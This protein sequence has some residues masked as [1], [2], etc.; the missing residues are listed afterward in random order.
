MPLKVVLAIDR[1]DDLGRKANI[2]S[3]VIGREENLN[4]AIALAAADPEDSDINTI[5]GALKIYDDL[6]R[7][8]EDVEIVTICGNES[9][10]LFSD[11]EIANQL[12]EIKRK[13]GAESVVVVTDGSED[14][15][16]MPIIS[17]RFKID[18]VRRI[19]V[20]Q[21]KTIESTYFM[22]KRMLNDPKI[23]RITLAPLG[24]I[25]LVYSIFLILRISEMGSG[26]IIFFIGFYLVLKA[27]GLESAIE[28]FFATLKKSL[29]EGRLSFITYV[30]AV[31]LFVIGA[32]QGFNAMWKVYTQPVSP[33]VL[34]LIISF[35]YGAVWW[36]VG[37][38]ISAVFGKVLDL[39]IEGKNFKKHLVVPFLLVSGALVL[40]GTSI[41]IL[42][43]YSSTR[44][45]FKIS[46]DSAFEY[47]LLSMAGAIL[48][49][50]VFIYPLTRRG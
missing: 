39:L 35:I 48:I 8:G 30:T 26:A 38:G 31:M 50:V 45:V 43:N 34:I 46:P 21:S 4:A 7:K 40:W 44:E 10:G 28:E 33:G 2:D 5:F 37:A 12:D 32:I 36:S 16:V 6:K 22:I 13:L 11:T 41:F 14:E 47:L 24:I 29:L 9:V 18:A 23:A 27:Y 20:K 49:A 42:S 25:L 19:V 3:P 1:D 15:V 17:S